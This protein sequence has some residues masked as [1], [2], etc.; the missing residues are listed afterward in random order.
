MADLGHHCYSPLM[1]AQ[2]VERILGKDEVIGSVS[3]VESVARLAERILGKDE[4]IG[5]ISLWGLRWKTA[6]IAEWFCKRKKRGY[7]SRL[8]F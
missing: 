6:K 1:Q 2:L 4:V 5:S 7:I 3:Y 8:C